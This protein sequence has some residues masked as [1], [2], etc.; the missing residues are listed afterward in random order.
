MYNLY[1]IKYNNYY[2]RLIKRS[3]YISD[4]LESDYIA[5]SDINFVSLDGV[6]SEQVINLK[7]DDLD[8]ENYDYLLVQDI[9]SN[10]F[11]RWFITKAV[12]TRKLQYSLSL[13]RDLISDNWKALKNA[14]IKVNRGYTNISSPYFFNK[15]AID[16]NTIPQ[17]QTYLKDD[18]GVS[19]L[20]AYLPKIASDVGVEKTLNSDGKTYTT[21]HWYEKKVNFQTSDLK[22]DYTATR[23]EVRA[24]L[25]NGRKIIGNGAV[26]GWY[27]LMTGDKFWLINYN[28]SSGTI[29]KK[30]I[31]YISQYAQTQYFTADNDTFRGNWELFL[32]N[33][34]DSINA[35]TYAQF[36]N[37]YKRYNDTIIEEIETDEETG[38]STTRYFKVAVTLEDADEENGMLNV[39]VSKLGT[40]IQSCY[41][42]GSY[43]SGNIN[44]ISYTIKPQTV[45]VT[46]TETQLSS[47]FF[48]YSASRVNTNGS[49]YDC[50]GVPYKDEFGNGATVNGLYHDPE[51]M[52]SLMSQLSATWGTSVVYDVQCIPYR[53]SINIIGE[54][55]KE[56]D[57]IWKD[58]TKTPIGY[59]Y[60]VQ[61]I[62]RTF[63]IDVAINASDNKAD[64]LTKHYKLIGGNYNSSFDLQVYENNGIDYF[65]VDM[66]LLPYNPWIKINPNFKYL[67]GKDFNDSRGLVLSGNFSIS[68]LTNSFTEYQYNN[69]NY[70]AIFNTQMDYTKYQQKEQLKSSVVSSMTSA[71]STA[72][73]ISSLGALGGPVGMAIGAVSGAVS[74]VAS[75][76]AGVYDISVQKRLNNKANEYTKQQYEL[77]LGNIKSKPT[78]LAKVTALNINTKMFPYIEEYGCTNEEYEQ[79]TKYLEYNGYSINAVGQMS[80]YLVSNCYFSGS[81]IRFKNVSINNYILGELNMELEKGFYIKEEE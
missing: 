29:Q 10:T 13:R 57:I 71:V 19:W 28:A 47:G 8:I 77:N 34:A 16:V 37:A 50:I 45:K 48:D 31:D 74:G 26:K 63:N 25:Y 2:N 78:T 68:M 76:L 52:M 17:S 51:T 59:V 6:N 23:D 49:A 11:T 70:E 54:L 14:I 55:N 66:T 73:Q 42:N 12:K 7:K 15:E 39:N 27:R 5:F 40:Y 20:V 67:N 79:V 62:N 65:N 53:P 3:D 22:A 41:D 80:E 4:Y 81:V 69:I 46:F 24:A 33:L 18:S 61:D 64:Y 36:N 32:S 56:Y 44:G 75:G 58:G 60:Y 9:D 38:E 21:T 35:K 1:L 30:K 43:H 72:G